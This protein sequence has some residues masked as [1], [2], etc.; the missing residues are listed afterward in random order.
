MLNTT[1]C[2]QKFENWKKLI[3]VADK[4]LNLEQNNIKAIYRKALALKNLQEFEPAIESIQKVLA[5]IDSD[6]SLKSKVDDSMLKEFNSLL[7]STEAAYQSYLKKQ[8]NMYKNMFS[9]S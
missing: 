2:L 3:V 8:K 6:P 4:I 5:N 9:A 1:L 7:K